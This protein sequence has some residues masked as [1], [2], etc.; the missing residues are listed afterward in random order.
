MTVRRKS[1]PKSKLKGQVDKGYKKFLKAH[2]MKLTK[3]GHNNNDRL[4]AHG[5]DGDVWPSGGW[6][7]P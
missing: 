5:D 2:K 4:R 7:M 3:Q 6:E 1:R